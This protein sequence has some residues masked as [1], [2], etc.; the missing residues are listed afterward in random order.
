MPVIYHLIFRNDVNTWEQELSK[1]NK[2][3]T[4]KWI[5]STTIGKLKRVC[6]NMSYP[7]PIGR[8]NWDRGISI[9]IM[10]HLG[11]PPVIKHGWLEKNPPFIFIYFHDVPS[12][13]NLGEVAGLGVCTNK[14]WRRSY[15]YASPNMMHTSGDIGFV[16]EAPGF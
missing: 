15:Q 11:Y 6:H 14:L 4:N 1:W 2:N 5:L 8:E 10:A 12:E 7:L 13:Q 9:M 16:S 3:K